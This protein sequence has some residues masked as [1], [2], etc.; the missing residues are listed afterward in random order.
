MDL[1]L[2]EK[3]ERLKLSWSKN[4]IHNGTGEQEG[5]CFTW[6]YTVIACG[7]QSKFK[8]YRKPTNRESLV[9][10]Y[11]ENSETV[12]RGITLGFFLRAYRIFGKVIALQKYLNE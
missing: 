3:L 6:I 12:K 1:Q 8:V 5:H 4:L 11:S 2:Q 9:H 10:F 7:E